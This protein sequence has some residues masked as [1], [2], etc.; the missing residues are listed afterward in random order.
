MKLA[1]KVLLLALLSGCGDGRTLDEIVTFPETSSLEPRVAA[2]LEAAR[3][4][5][6]SDPRDVIAWRNLG[7]VLDAHRFTP[8]AE[9]AYREALRL[10]D[11]F[12]KTGEHP[13]AKKVMKTEKTHSDPLKKFQ[14]THQ[15]LG[16]N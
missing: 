7:A 2:A 1:S 9:S 13:R 6:E 16:A 14:V 4:K 5:V 8:P 12:K 11:G 15:A 10:E 3:D